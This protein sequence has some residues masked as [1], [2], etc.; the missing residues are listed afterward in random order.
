MFYFFPFRNPAQSPTVHLTCLLVSCSLWQFLSLSWSFL[1][2]TCRW[3]LFGSF[4]GVMFPHDTK[5]YSRNRHDKRMS[6]VFSFCICNNTK[7]K[8]LARLL[9]NNFCVLFIASH[10]GY[11]MS[12]CPT[13]GD[14]NLDHWLKW[15]I[16]CFPLQ[17]Y[18][19]FRFS[20]AIS[21]S[22]YFRPMRMSCLFSNFV[23]WY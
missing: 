1:T 8:L 7:V 20:R 9:Q 13:T 10:L 11:T 21:W 15:Y 23:H 22:R 6:C 4:V 19:F 12:T 2:V 14:V 18:F 5:W 16:L 3:V 17:S